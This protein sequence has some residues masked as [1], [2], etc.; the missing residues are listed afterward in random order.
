LTPI[1]LK[2]I[3]KFSDIYETVKNNKDVII[4]SL[5]KEEKQF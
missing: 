2:V 4:T 1:V 3:D 5:E